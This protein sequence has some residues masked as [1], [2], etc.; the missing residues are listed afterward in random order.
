MAESRNPNAVPAFS[1]L[2]SVYHGSSPIELDRCLASVAAQDVLPAQTVVVRDGP[3]DQGVVDVLARYA[4]ALSMVEEVLARNSGLGTALAAGLARCECDLVA[5]MDTDDR[6]A[7]GRFRKQVQFLARHPE[8]AVVGGVQREFRRGGR[9]YAD[10]RLPESTA[11]IAAFAKRRNP[12]NHPTVMFRRPAIVD[13]GGYR[14][15][16]LL[17][18]YD[19]WVR[20]LLA[21]HHLA[22][23]PDVLV[24]SEVDDALYS[25]RGGL[26][27]VKSE[28]RLAAE[29]RRSR[30][31]TLSE[32]LLFLAARLPMR[33]V[34]P[35]YRS[36]LYRRV[37]RDERG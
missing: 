16:H 6:C 17:E 10:R 32:S 9:G 28:W 29:F 30:F 20:V 26:R 22:N 24:E 34:S 14:S 19:L 4:E 1:L 25:R 37:L 35:R 15:F 3:V 27:Y 7:S 11:A 12:L 8:V 33:L 23:L 13:V 5:R 36:A 2:M 21:G 31:H 18:D